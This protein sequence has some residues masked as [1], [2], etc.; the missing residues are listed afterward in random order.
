MSVLGE[1]HR[2]RESGETVR[3]YLDAVDA[4]DDIRRLAEL[5]ER[6][7]YQGTVTEAAA[8]EAIEIA[9]SVVA[10]R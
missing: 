10:R 1:Q 9:D 2:P 5:R 8:A 4:G 6:L 7:R 3:V